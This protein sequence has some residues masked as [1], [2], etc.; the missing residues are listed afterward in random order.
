MKVDAVNSVRSFK[1]N[2]KSN[3]P[4]AGMSAV[5][6][7]AG[8]PVEAAK[9]MPWLAR[10]LMYVGQN[11]GE[12]LNTLVTAFGT[13]VIAPIFIA[14][15]PISKEDKE[16]KWY[17]A[18]RQPISAVIA[19]IMQIGVNNVYNGYMQK[20]ASNGFLGEHMNLIAEPEA[21]Y[22]RKIIKLEHPEFTD[23]QISDEITR[24]QNIAN[25]TELNKLRRLMADTEITLE[26]LV[27]SEAMKEARNEMERELKEQFKDDLSSM[28]KKKAENFLRERLPEEKV[29]AR[30]LENI[31]RQVNFETTVKHEIR[32]LKVRFQNGEVAN[33]DSAIAEIKTKTKELGDDV[34]DK[35]VQKLTEAKT[36]EVANEARPFS[37]IP[38]YCGPNKLSRENVLHNVK[39]KKL[40]K[41]RISNAKK[42]FSKT[43]NIGGIVVSL[44]TLPISC[45]LLNWAYPRVMER[46]MPK[47]QPWI[48]RNDPDWTPEKAKKYGPPPKVVKVKEEVDND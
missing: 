35:I 6:F 3:T 17:S 37:S 44:V 16:T 25:K 12:I 40:L 13:A 20:M 7:G 32:K 38:N 26:Q 2:N 47:L 18:M 27:D 48:H 4:K 29:R 21:N 14:G 31:E 33:I 23:K 1:N 43:K 39:V 15:N 45:G 28:S 19:M 10:A 24:R 36:Y 42:F 8:V 41:V 22:L 46:V 34:V 30:A 5:S 9:K 11:D